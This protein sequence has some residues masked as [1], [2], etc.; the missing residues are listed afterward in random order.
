[1]A[2]SS[3]NNKH[4]HNVNVDDFRCK[5]LKWYDKNQR[6][7]PWRSVGKK[8]PNPYHVWLSE[9]MLQQTTVATVGP[10][11]EKFSK[12][13]PTVHDLAVADKEDVM[14]EWAGLGYYARARNLYKCAQ[15]I[16]VELNGIFP[17][18]QQE[19]EKLPGIGGYTSAAVRAIAF[20][21]PANVVDGNIERVMARIYAVTEPVPDSKPQLKKLAGGLADD[22]ED[23]PGDYAQALMDL[24][25]GICTPKSPK[26]ML[27]PV[28]DICEAKKQGIAETLPARKTKKPK[29]QKHGAVYWITND[30]N[31]VCFI[32]R[33]ETEMLGGML[34]LPTSEWVITETKVKPEKG[35]KP[36]GQFITHSFTHFDLRL[37]IYTKNLKNGIKL[38]QNNPIWLSALELDSL[39]LPT[40]FKKVVKFMK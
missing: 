40:L 24:G 9:I 19:L 34:G 29:P 10:Y 32:R 23:R 22:K 1:M 18:T 31:E 17:D 11:F 39:G 7:L 4:A 5:I 8:K 27:C 13:W 25:A 38:P 28:M 16:S 33:D 21:K 35:F 15:V 37:D 36:L 14:H 12:R 3:P 2:N 20:N 26:C 30:R 6:V